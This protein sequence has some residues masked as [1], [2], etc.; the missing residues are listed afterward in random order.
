VNTALLELIRYKAWATLRVIDHCQTLDDRELD[1]TTP[2]TYGT[3]RETLSH[4]VSSDEDYL[5][6]LTGEPYS[7]PPPDAPRTLDGLA[8]DVRR[9]GRRW[10]EVIGGGVPEMATASDGYHMPGWVPVAQAIHHADDHRTHV[11]SILGARGL[12]APRLD[13]WAYSRFLR[14]LLNPSGEPD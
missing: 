9:V 1:A 3:I 8:Q 4:L 14:V 13:V 7:P 2:G 11:L 10:E 12:D 6:F 5:S